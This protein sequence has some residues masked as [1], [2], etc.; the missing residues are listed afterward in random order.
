MPGLGLNIKSSY[1]LWE[2]KDGDL[3]KVEKALIIGDVGTSAASLF[4]ARGTILSGAWEAGKF[5][6]NLKW[7]YKQDKRMEQLRRGAIK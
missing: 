4:G 3:S 6:N 2:S 1:D 7:Q 5:A